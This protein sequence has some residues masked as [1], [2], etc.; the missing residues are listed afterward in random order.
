MK[1]AIDVAVNKIEELGIGIRKVNYKMRDA[2]FS[3]QRYWGE[4]FPIK[5]IDGI[6]HPLD[7]SELPLTLPHVDKYGPG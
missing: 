6:A 1:D 4:P 5:W 2:A 3:R 7:E